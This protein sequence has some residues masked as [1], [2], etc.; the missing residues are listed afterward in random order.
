MSKE[1]VWPLLIARDEQGQGHKVELT[2]GGRRCL[3]RPGLSHSPSPGLRPSTCLSVPLRLLPLTSNPSIPGRGRKRTGSLRGRGARAGQGGVCSTHIGFEVT[4]CRMTWGA[5]VGV[6]GT[7]T[8]STS[9]R[10][11]KQNTNVESTT[12]PKPNSWKMLA[13]NK[14]SP[15]P[16]GLG[17]ANPLSSCLDH[18]NFTCLDPPVF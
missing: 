9:Q 6:S 2:R 1:M 13:A 10:L 14:F 3:S 18:L 17:L 11:G 4:G 15:D 5:R 8:T 16:G 12:A 7:G